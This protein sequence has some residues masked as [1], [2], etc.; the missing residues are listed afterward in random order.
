MCGKFLQVPWVARSRWQSALQ[1]RQQAA[2][3]SVT[4]L[5][6]KGAVVGLLRQELLYA[7]WRRPGQLATGMADKTLNVRYKSTADVCGTRYLTR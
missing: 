4:G 7:A 3:H 1:R 2:Q 6:E 5:G